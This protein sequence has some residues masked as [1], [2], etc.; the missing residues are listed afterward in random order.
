MHDFI[1]KFNMRTKYFHVHVFIYKTIYS[2]ISVM[3]VTL[4]VNIFNR[5]ME[6]WL[7]FREW[8][9]LVCSL[10][11]TGFREV[12][13]LFHWI[14]TL[15]TFD[16]FNYNNYKYNKYNFIFTHLKRSLFQHGT[17][18]VWFHYL[19]S[20]HIGTDQRGWPETSWWSGS[21]R[22]YCRRCCWLRSARRQATNALCIHHSRCSSSSLCRRHSLLDLHWDASETLSAEEAAR[23]Q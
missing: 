11:T 21:R 20:Q 6:L 3:L 15:C 10:F 9:L 23:L 22:W 5:N 8:C 7:H 4:L 1:N 18:A 16:T 13:F 17:L 2:G 14:Y 12:A 19:Y